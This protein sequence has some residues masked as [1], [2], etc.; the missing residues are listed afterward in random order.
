MKYKLFISDY[1]GTLGKAPE[2]DIDFETRKAISEFTRKGGIFTVC[3][4]RETGSINKILKPQGLEGL[5]VSLQGAHISD[6][7]TGQTI[8]YGGL[9]KKTATSVLDAV[10]DSGLVPLI[11][12]NGDLYYQKD[13]E[14]T[15]VY[16]KNV[17]IDGIVTNVREQV[18]K[19]DGIISKICWLG[20]DKIVNQTAEKLNAIY[21]GKKVKFNSGAP[22]LLEAIN[23]ECGK[24]FA[25][26]FI[27]DYYN[28]PLDQ[29]IAVGD[30]TN[31]VELI[32]GPWHGVAVGDGREELKAVADEITVPFDQKPVKVLLE[33]YCLSD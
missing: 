23:P 1:D 10:Q 22:C 8:Y 31:D 29:V 24:G 6:I 28:I 9:D 30:S 4:G 3:S 27:A 18:E 19:I 5:V 15:D 32:S 14:Y 11:Y 21:K 20:D 16:I 17:M 25:V 13:T 33:K 2:N 26:K 12:H 7:Q